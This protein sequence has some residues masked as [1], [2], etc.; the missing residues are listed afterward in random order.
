MHELGVKTLHGSATR[1]GGNQ[2]PVPD[3]DRPFPDED[4]PFPDE[5]RPLPFPD[6][7]SCLEIFLKEMQAV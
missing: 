5:D 7:N 4:R 2:M 1:T 6:E 3:E